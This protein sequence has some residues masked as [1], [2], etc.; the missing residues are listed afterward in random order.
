VV[1]LIRG[2]TDVDEQESRA[3]DRSE[4]MTQVPAQW[5]RLDSVNSRAG[6]Q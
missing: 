6:P 5:A 3:Y 1:A 4:F 2:G